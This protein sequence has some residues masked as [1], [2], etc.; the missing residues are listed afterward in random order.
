MF[1]SRN[2]NLQ[3]LSDN[4]KYARTKTPTELGVKPGIL[5]PQGASME[6]IKHFISKMQKAYSPLKKL[7]NLLGATSTIYNSVSSICI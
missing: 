6:V 2:G 5:P 4:I 1:F 7:E 3:Q